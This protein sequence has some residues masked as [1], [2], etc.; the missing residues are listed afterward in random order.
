MRLPLL[1][2]AVASAGF[3]PAP[4]LN[5]ETRTSLASLQGSWRRLVYTNAGSPISLSW[6]DGPPVHLVVEG[7]VLSYTQGPTTT[8]GVW[9]FAL[10]ERT[11]PVGVRM[12]WRKADGTHLGVIK[13]EGDTLTVCTAYSGAAA[14]DFDP[15][16]PGRYFSVFKRAPKGTK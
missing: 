4:F 6:S 1:A 10:D 3:A 11:K 8:H 13:I 9:D 5:P 15:K 16:P 7:N 14:A 12:K 2:L